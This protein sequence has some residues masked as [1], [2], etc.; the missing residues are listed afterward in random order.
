MVVFEPAVFL[1]VL[2][3]ISGAEKV[4]DHSACV[5]EATVFQ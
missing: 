1:S 5:F 3:K 2:G 4:M